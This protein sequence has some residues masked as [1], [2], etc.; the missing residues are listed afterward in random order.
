MPEQEGK[1]IVDGTLSIVKVGVADPAGLNIYNDLAW[2]G[3]RNVNRFNRNGFALCFGH[4][5]AH[6]MWH[7]C[8]SLPRAD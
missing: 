5:P 6:V 1:I 3:V 2:S 4:D 8:T 7:C